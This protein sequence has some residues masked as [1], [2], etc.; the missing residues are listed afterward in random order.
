MAELE[1]SSINP[2]WKYLSASSRSRSNVSQ[3]CPRQPYL[4]LSFPYPPISTSA[5]LVRRIRLATVSHDQGKADDPGSN[6]TYQD[7]HTYF[8]IEVRAPT[9]LARIRRQR[10]IQNIRASSNPRKHVVDWVLKQESAK[11]VQHH[12]I[13]S[14]DD[15]NWLSNIQGGDTVQI[16]PMA[17]YPGWINFVVEARIEVWFEIIDHH[18][19]PAR[20]L[21]IP[22][23]LRPLYGQ[24]DG[25]R[26]EIRLIIIEPSSDKESDVLQLSLTRTYL[27]ND[28]HIQY[29]AL[30]YC[31]GDDFEQRS[32]LLTG[33]HQLLPAT[34]VYVGSNLFLA[35][36]TLRNEHTARVF[37]IDQLCI[38]QADL[39]ERAEQVALM[40]E[41]YTNAKH[42]CVWLGELDGSIS[43]DFA[44]IRTIFD[45]HSQGKL[46]SQGSISC[47]SNGSNSDGL[48][49]TGPS[50][51]I[52]ISHKVIHTPG[53]VSMHNDRIF[54]RPWFERVWV[55]QEVWNTP[56]GCS[57]L[58]LFRRVTVMCG[59]AELPWTAVLRA[60]Q[61]L[62]SRNGSVYNALMPAIW[63]TLFKTPE[64]PEGLTQDDIY[65]VPQPRPDILTILINALEMRATDPRD[66]LFALLAFGKETYGVSDLPDLVKPDYNKSVRRVYVDFTRWWIQHHRSLRILSAVHTLTGRSWLDGSKCEAFRANNSA[67]PSIP[68]W[69]FSSDGHGVWRRA[70]LGIGG[71]E[72]YKASGGRDVDVDFLNS[73]MPLRRYVLA[74]K[75]IRIGAI[76][77]TAYYPFYRRPVVSESMHE[78]YAKIFDPSSTIGTW[79]HRKIQSHLPLFDHGQLPYHYF[80]HWR[81]VSRTSLDSDSGQTDPNAPDYLPCHGKCMFSTE[82]ALGLCPDGSRVGDLVVILFGSD[83]PHL[84]RKSDE[85]GGYYFVGECYIDGIMHGEAFGGK[86]VLG[87]ETFLLI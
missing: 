50:V 31:W 41:I 69:S 39:E 43:E 87:E 59:G 25:S 18:D 42:V 23:S 6:G 13:G 64:R 84:L 71:T 29:E 45:A 16:I 34:Q 56:Q 40:G 4:S 46:T 53:G 10:L 15:G 48:I 85:P 36:K 35:L 74:L 33:A 12:V 47:S 26:K 72:T 57:I 44:N 70:T 5:L 79:G 9:G 61:C 8:D 62:R 1:G 54:D 76:R 52:D 28:D 65:F 67:R 75:G 58:D 38:N 55:L 49:P 83:V 30:S 51:P 80:T 11:E 7:S 21:T 86:D 82:A 81:N 17:E 22:S 78:V 19:G 77:S 73:T 66:K 14:N 3:Y 2:S 27:T 20:V 24:L 68:S 37:W 60:N 32:I 63:G